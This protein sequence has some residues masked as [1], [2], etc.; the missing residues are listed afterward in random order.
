MANNLCFMKGE[1]HMY[2]VF[3][4]KNYRF[5]NNNFLTKF[6]HY[7]KKKDLLSI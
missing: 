3:L 1:L 7:I 6:Y 5:K 2:T 4:Y